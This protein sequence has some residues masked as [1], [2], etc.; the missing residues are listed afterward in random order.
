VSN[1]SGFLAFLRSE[2]IFNISILTYC[3]FNC[4]CEEL[5]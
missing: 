2:I 1:T 3:K 4:K 5:G